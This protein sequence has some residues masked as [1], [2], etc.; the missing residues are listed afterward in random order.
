M[1]S[2]ARWWEDVVG[3]DSTLAPFAAPYRMWVKGALHMRP[4]HDNEPRPGAR[5]IGRGREGN[6]RQLRGKRLVFTTGAS[7]AAQHEVRLLEIHARRHDNRTHPAE[8]GAQLA[9]V[10]VEMWL[11]FLGTDVSMHRRTVDVGINRSERSKIDSKVSTASKVSQVRR[12][13]N[14]P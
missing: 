12:P 14:T 7:A 1:V 11:L 10:D 13:T 9:L 4:C 8:C 6:E 3:C 5:D 2:S